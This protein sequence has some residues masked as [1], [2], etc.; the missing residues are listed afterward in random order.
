MEWLLFIPIVLI[1]GV[2]VYLVLDFDDHVNGEK[3]PE[4]WQL[5]H[6]LPVRK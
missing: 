4:K 5:P 2:I 6:G 1:G 3:E